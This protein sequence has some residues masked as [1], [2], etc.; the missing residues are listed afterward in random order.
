MLRQRM[1]RSNERVFFVG[2]AG[3]DRY[4]KCARSN[5]KLL[6]ALKRM[7]DIIISANATLAQV[8]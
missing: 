4:K 8:R 5:V 7:T 2:G 6:A 3:E 1:A